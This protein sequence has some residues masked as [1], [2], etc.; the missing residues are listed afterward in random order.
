M[1]PPAGTEARR[2]AMLEIVELDADVFL[3]SLFL[4]HR[5]PHFIDAA[6]LNPS[7]CNAPMTLDP[8]SSEARDMDGR[9]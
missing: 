6:T 7:P 9:D 4:Q 2:K 3:R 5:Y 1:T 8:R